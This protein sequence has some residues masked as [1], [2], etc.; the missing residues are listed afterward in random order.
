MPKVEAGRSVPAGPQIVSDEI[1]TPAKRRQVS[2]PGL[3]TFVALANLWNLTE[4]QRL[5]MLGSPSRSTYY[6]WVKAVQQHRDLTLDFDTLVRI[7]AVL[8]IWSALRIL[9]ET[10]AEGIAWLRGHHRAL[11]FGGRAPLEVMASGTQ[12]ALLTTRRFLDAARGGLYMEPNE[13]DENFEPYRD[14]DIAWS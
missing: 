8:G 1:F 10:E 6:N 13:I 3:R 4:E 12:D 9:R 5:R 11:V 14:E 2:G 7:S